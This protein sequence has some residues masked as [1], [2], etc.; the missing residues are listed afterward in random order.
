MQTG[1][2]VNF[3]RTKILERAN[4]L[5]TILTRKI[6]EIEKEVQRPN[7]RDDNKALSATWKLLLHREKENEDRKRGHR[8]I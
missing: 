5:L 3:D 8:R 2:K 4:L 7:K 1:H 6:I